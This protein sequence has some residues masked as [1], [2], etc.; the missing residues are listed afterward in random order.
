MYY[1]TFSFYLARRQGNSTLR[2]GRRCKAQSGRQD[3]PRYGGTFCALQRFCRVS[4]QARLYSGDERP[5]RTRT[6]R[7]KGQFGVRGGRYV[8]QQ[9]ARSVG[10]FRLLPRKVRLAAVYDG[11]QLRQFRNAS[12]RGAAPRSKR[13]HSLRVKLHQRRKFHALRHCGAVYVPSQGRTLSRGT[14]RQTVLQK[15]RK[16]VRRS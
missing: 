13:I 15:L 5:P 16:E 11:A 3:S 8:L 9:R 4:Q 10:Y 2:M 14:H 6:Q 1:E 7:R 12:R